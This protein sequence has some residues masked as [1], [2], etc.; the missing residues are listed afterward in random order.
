MVQ[1]KITFVFSI[2]LQSDDLKVLKQIQ[3][4][5][6]IGNIRINKDKCVFTV[7]NIE[8]TYHLI[9]IFDKYNL[10]STKYLNYFNF[11]KAFMIYQGRNK[12]LLKSD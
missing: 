7:T 6:G 9:S 10:N 4:K 2:E 11:R 8:G 12:Q 1:K 3:E 5:L